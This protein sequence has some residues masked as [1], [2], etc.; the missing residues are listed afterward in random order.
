[1]THLNPNYTYSIINLTTGKTLVNSKYLGSC[2]GYKEHC[3]LSPADQL[4]HRYWYHIC[5]RKTVQLALICNETNDPVLAKPTIYNEDVAWPETGEIIYENNNP[6]YRAYPE[7]FV[8]N[9]KFE[10][11]EEFV[12]NIIPILKARGLVEGV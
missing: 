8:D 2:Y 5:R 11:E 12:K 6:K 3:I 1:M 10:M 9:P 7:Y 4:L